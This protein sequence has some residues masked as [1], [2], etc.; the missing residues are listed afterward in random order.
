LKTTAAVLLLTAAFPLIGNATQIKIPTVSTSH[1]AVRSNPPVADEVVVP[2]I[3]KPKTVD[4]SRS[5]LF[6]LTYQ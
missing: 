1:V 6:K 2:I 3:H 5:N 4:A